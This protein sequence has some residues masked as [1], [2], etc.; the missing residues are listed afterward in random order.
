MGTHD[1]ERLGQRSNWIRESRVGSS[2]GELHREG[3]GTLQVRPVSMLPLQ[4]VHM[5]HLPVNVHRT[6]C[7]ASGRHRNVEIEPLWLMTHEQRGGEVSRTGICDLLKPC[8][9]CWAWWHLSVILPF[10][11]EMKE[12]ALEVQGQPRLHEFEG[13]LGY[14]RLR[15]KDKLMN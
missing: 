7:P 5:V 10:G 11:R 9:S 14:M 15:L 12:E 1:S 13:S 3:Q 8:L 4:L 6:A 2:L